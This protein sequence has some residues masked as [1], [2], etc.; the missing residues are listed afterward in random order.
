MTTET[1]ICALNDGLMAKANSDSGS[2]NRL[3]PRVRT[4]TQGLDLRL[5]IRDFGRGLRQPNAGTATPGVGLRGMQERLR[6]LGGTLQIDSTEKGT[7][8]AA[9]VPVSD[10]PSEGAA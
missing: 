7:T 10:Q 5:E 9:L 2:L 4:R 3:L 1:L 8:V 6:Q